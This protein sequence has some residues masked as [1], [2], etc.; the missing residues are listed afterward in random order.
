MAQV[1]LENLWKVFNGKVEAVKGVTM[2]IPD[3]TVVCLLGPSGCGKTTVMRMIAGLETPTRGS[4]YFDDR[5][6]THLKPSERNVAMVFQFPAVYPHLN[7]LQNISFPLIAEG[8]SKAEVEQRVQEVALVLGLTDVLKEMPKALDTGSRQ[9]VAIG[10][11][12]VRRPRVF[13]FD[14]P[15]SNIDPNVRVEM[16]SI[17]KQLSRDLGQTFIYVTHD[18]SEAMTLADQIAVMKDGELLQFDS[19][20]EVYERPA[21]TFVGW[22]LGN[23]GMNYVGA[24]VRDGGAGK[25]ELF[26]DTFSLKVDA[27]KVAAGTAALSGRKVRIGIRPEHIRISREEQGGNWIKGQC[28][29]TEPMGAR[30]IVHVRINGDQIRIKT[31]PTDVI[32]EGDEVWV[33][34]PE[35]HIRLFDADTGVRIGN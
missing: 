28:A 32:R 26:S 21:N 27:G 8:L 12:I 14:E 2:T 4:V 35:D 23:P 10:R 22:F 5:D 34:F 30:E 19:P 13:I 25:I 24:Q 29:L 7:V 3:K 16:K 18:Q 20:E 1:R 17:I 9:R 15:L 6:V 31:L 33:Y 11:A